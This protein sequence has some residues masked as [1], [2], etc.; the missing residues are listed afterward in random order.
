M[1]NTRHYTAL[2]LAGTAPFVACAL[3]P[4]IGIRAIPP[5]GSL[6][7][8]ASTYG[9]AIVCF[10]AGTHWGQFLSGRSANSLNLFVISNIIFL[11]T[12]FGFI[13][14]SLEWAIAIQIAAFLA[15]LSIDH[16]MQAN[17]VISAHYFGIRAVATSIA[18]VSLLLVLLLQ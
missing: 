12:W 8:I 15:L 11:I 18:T 3:L 7:A 13:G 14:P 1:Q 6:D 10:V 5:L 17:S 4:I 16:R 2:A 9:L